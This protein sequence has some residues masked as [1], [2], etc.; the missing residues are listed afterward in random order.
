MV[1]SVGGRHKAAG[2]DDAG[3]CGKIKKPALGV[4]GLSRLAC[5]ETDP[6][7]AKD[8]GVRLE[9]VTW[10]S[11]EGLHSCGTAPASHRLSPSS[12]RN[13]MRPGPCRIRLLDESHC[14]LS[15]P[16]RQGGRREV[17]GLGTGD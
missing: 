15:R 10:L 6:F 17:R 2:G 7:R 12:A 11:P 4:G 16:G 14:R 13:S 3:G 5:H 9:R 8:F 1:P